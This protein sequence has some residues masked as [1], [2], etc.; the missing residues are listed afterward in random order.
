M[1]KMAA[2]QLRAVRRIPFLQELKGQWKGTRQRSY[3]AVV[4]QILWHVL[5]FFKR[6]CDRQVYE[7]WVKEVTSAAETAIVVWAK[8]KLGIQEEQLHIQQ[9][10]QVDRQQLEEA[11][12]AA[13][14]SND[15]RADRK[16][17]IEEEQLLV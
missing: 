13:G 4:H 3:T 17:A 11:K 7:Q 16:L 6:C 14:S 15:A 12:N 9:V 1:L 2:K 8:R 5:R 10:L